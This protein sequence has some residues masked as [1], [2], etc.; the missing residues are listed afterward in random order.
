MS[1]RHGY[2]SPPEG[3]KQSVEVAYNG[4]YSPSNSS[5]LTESRSK[6]TIV[7]VKIVVDTNV[8]L[9]VALDEPERTGIIALTSGHELIAPEVLPFEIGNALSVLVKRQKLDEQ[10]ALVAWKT[11]HDIPV[12]LRSIDIKSALEIAMQN[13]IYAYDAYFI[14]CAFS[15]LCPLLT[16]DNKMK[17]VARSLGIKVLES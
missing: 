4:Q 9:A 7:L 12:D 10:E 5:G 1:S 13:G 16:L 14:E 8:F 3:T 17:S 6:S 2:S 11:C 15:L